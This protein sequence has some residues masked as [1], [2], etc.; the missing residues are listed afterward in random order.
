MRKND[1]Y[2]TNVRRGKRKRGKN[3]HIVYSRHNSKQA[4]I[5]KKCKA[6]QSRRVK[7]TSRRGEGSEKS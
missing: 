1:L 5:S 4:C 3:A 7:P 2:K 6:V